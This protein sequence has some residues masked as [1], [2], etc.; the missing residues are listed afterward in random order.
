MLR[1]VGLVDQ[2]RLIEER[3]PDGWG[4]ARLQLRVSDAA[5]CDR[6]AGLLGPLN[7]GRRGR[8]LRF[9][10]SRRGS[11][12]RPD[13]IARLLSRLDDEGVGGNLELVSAGKPEPAAVSRQRRTLA[14][15]WDALL[16]ALPPDWS[17]LYAEVELASTDHLDRGALLLA[18]VNP[19]RYGGKPAFRFRC[20]RRFG[21]G[22]SAG[23]AR[24]A[25]ERL[26]EEGIR[27]AV[28]P[29]RVLSDT[30]PVATQGP[31]WRVGGRAV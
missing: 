2:W 16:A 3:L 20:A 11:G 4:D 14:E 9:F 15:S 5:R 10:T 25:L 31:V 1:L 7:P 28:R 6:A 29:V 12:H 18:P 26:D 8:E 30:R 23:M 24:R 27:G 22:V 21:Y 17:D 19:A 13:V